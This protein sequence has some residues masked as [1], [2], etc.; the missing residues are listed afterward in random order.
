M[1]GWMEVMD[2]RKGRWRDDG[3]TDNERMKRSGM[4]GWEDE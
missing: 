2:G 1:D 3:K 4:D